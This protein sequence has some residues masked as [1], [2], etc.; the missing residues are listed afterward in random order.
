MICNKFDT[1]PFMPFFIKIFA[2]MNC[3]NNFFLRKWCHCPVAQ[4]WLLAPYGNYLFKQEAIDKLHYKTI[5][6]KLQFEIA[7]FGPKQ[8]MSSL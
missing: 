2:T 7:I 5:C 8:F 3:T 4:K 1:T 6:K